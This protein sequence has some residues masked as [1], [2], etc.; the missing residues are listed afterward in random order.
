MSEFFARAKWLLILALV[1]IVGSG[2]SDTALAGPISPGYDLLATVPGTA[3]ITLPGGTFALNGKGIQGTTTD[4]IIQLK[5]SLPAGGTGT[6]P[7]EIVAL[8]LMSTMPVLNPLNNGSTHFFNINV[9]IN[10]GLFSQSDLPQ[11]D[12]LTPSL[13]N[14]NILTH[15]DAPPPGGGTFNSFFDVFA[16]IILTDVTDGTQSSH[17]SSPDVPLGPPSSPNNWTHTASPSNGVWLTGGWAA[18]GVVQHTGPHPQ[19]IPAQGQ[20][21]SPLPEPGTL[22]LLAGG[23]LSLACARWKAVVFHRL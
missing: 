11:P 10:K 1:L 9:D 17:S 7:A 20:A 21:P 18:V 14:I 15:V 23:I 4:T 2:L 6:I 8:S 12:A 13:G 22:A 5:G 3:T 16:D 19:T